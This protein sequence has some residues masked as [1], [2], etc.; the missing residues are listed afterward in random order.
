MK[1]KTEKLLAAAVTHP[2]EDVKHYSGSPFHSHSL[3]LYQRRKRFVLIWQE[4]GGKGIAEGTLEGASP[5]EILA[6]LSREQGSHNDISLSRALAD[7]VEE[8][9]G[10]PLVKA[11]SDPFLGWLSQEEAPQWSG[12]EGVWQEVRIWDELPWGGSTYTALVTEH[13]LKYGHS[14]QRAWVRHG[15]PAQLAQALGQLSEGLHIW[16]AI[17]FLLEAESL[18]GAEELPDGRELRVYRSPL[19]GQVRV[20]VTPA[21]SHFPDPRLYRPPRFQVEVG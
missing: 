9:Y 5:G 14:L 6:A 17:R 2:D 16:K 20:R 15:H 4:G 19:V 11:K 8:A 1:K 18:I 13:I 7:L 21:N 3:Y 12:Q 10:E